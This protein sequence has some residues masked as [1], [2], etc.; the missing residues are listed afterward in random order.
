[1]ILKEYIKSKFSIFNIGV[2]A[3]KPRIIENGYF[4]IGFN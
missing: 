3:V 4:I 1:M 2:G